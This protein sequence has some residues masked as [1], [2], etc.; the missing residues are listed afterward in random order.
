MTYQR[1]GV[2]AYWRVTPWFSSD[3]VRV[4]PPDAVLKWADPA[5]TVTVFRLACAT[6]L[7]PMRVL[8]AGAAGSVTVN[9]AAVVS[10]G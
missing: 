10:H 8:S 1:A 5:L 2:A 3:R 9:P 6:I 4:V 7:N